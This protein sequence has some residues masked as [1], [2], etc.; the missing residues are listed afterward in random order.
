MIRPMNT[1]LVFALLWLL[2]LSDMHFYAIDY[3]IQIASLVYYNILG[4]KKFWLQ[5]H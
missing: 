1:N 3:R 5:F 4:N 2:N